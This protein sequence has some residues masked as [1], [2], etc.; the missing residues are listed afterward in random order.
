M[1]KVKELTGYIMP[2]GLAFILMVKL[3]SSRFPKITVLRGIVALLIPI[4]AWSYLTGAVLENYV[5]SRN[6]KQSKSMPTIA[7]WVDLLEEDN[8]VY[9]LEDTHNFRWAEGI[10]FMMQDKPLILTKTTE[11]SFEEDA[12]FIMHRN[13][14]EN[15]AIKENCEIVVEMGEFALAINKNQEVMKRF[16]NYRTD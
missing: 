13:F 11:V 15:D 14:V 2:L 12:F 7:M 1:G 3:F 8:Q 6:E 4:M 10:Q 9:Y 5:I 16:E